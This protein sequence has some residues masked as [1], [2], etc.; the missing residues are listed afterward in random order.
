MIILLIPGLWAQQLYNLQT[1][2]MNMIYYSSAHSYI[3]PHLARSYLRTWDYYQ[4]FWNYKPY[5]ETTLFIEDF[6]DWANGGATAVPRNFV[7]ISMSPYMYVFEVAPANERMS[8]L[9]H[10]ELTHVVAM[11]MSTNHDSFFRDI[12]GGKIQQVSDNPLSLLYAY[13]TTPR[14]YA[15]RWYHEGIAV[16]ME[17]WMSGGI[18]RS[19][20]SY[21]EMVFRSMVRDSTHIYDLVGLEA[22]GTAIDFQVGANSYLYGTRFFSYLGQKYGPNKLI[23]WVKR[24]DDSKAYFSKQFQKVFQRRLSDEWQDWISFEHEFQQQNLKRIRQNPVTKI[25]PITKQAMGSVSRSFYDREKQKLYTAV[26]FP[27]EIPHILEIDLT[28]GKKR[29]I[30]NIKAASTY[31][32]T[33]LAW[34]K[35]ED[36]LFF[37]SDNYYRRDLNVVDIQSGKT[38]RIFTDLR[39][40]E[41]AFNKIDKSLWGV[42]HENGISTIVR[43]ES[44]YTDWQAIYAFPYGS[45]I[46]DLDI[47]PDG[48]KLTGAITHINGIQELACFDLPKLQEGD[49]S[50][51]QIYDFDYSSPA[52]FVF[53][54]D[55]RYLYGTSYY[56]GVSNVY[57]YDFSLDDISIVSNCETGFFRPIPVN[58]DSLIVFN[59]VGGKGWIPG[60]IENNALENVSAIEYLGQKVIDKYPYVKEWND[61]SPAQIDL[62]SR[63]SYKGEYKLLK[64]INLNGA[65]PIVEGYKDGAALGYHLD[66]QDAIGFSRFSLDVSYS[67]EENLSKDEKIHLKGKYHYKKYTFKADYNTADFFDL[68]GPTKVSRMGY[69]YGL[70]FDHSFINDKPRTLDFNLDLIGY[71]GLEIL[72]DFQNITAGYDEMYKASA[73]LDYRYIQKSLGAVDGE[74]GYNLSSTLASSFVNGEFYPKM[75]CIGDIGFPFLLHHASLWLRNSAGYNFSNLDNSFARYYFGGFGNNWV[76]HQKEQRYRQYYSYPGLEINEIGGKSFAKSMLEFNLPPVRFRKVGTSAFYARWLRPALFGSIISTNALDKSEREFYYNAGIQWDIR[77]ITLSLLKTTFSVGFAAAWDEDL[78]RSEE[79]MVSLK[80]F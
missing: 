65:Y 12:F 21:D 49:T 59:Y 78:N 35:E 33:S 44:P 71:G 32:T 75:H 48:S 38:T 6:S 22:E 5:E 67:T 41:L 1:D 51:Q 19:L 79:L 8:L 40:G 10:H 62:E 47:S 14:K 31:Y 7:Y 64:N 74:K 61:G 54:D 9:M 80:L 43:L 34:D 13:L 57:C 25:K 23:E 76:D 63:Q 72:P 3:I 29:K 53:S 46:Y 28:T 20:G 66:W 42:R 17:T 36:K 37:T 58:S 50:Y 30:C 70:S 16:S 24:D 55:G 15:P 27:G 4:D 18:G 2:D 68:F 45:D 60:W 52:N 73:T 39:A 11:D 26:K 56:S 77:F 69:S